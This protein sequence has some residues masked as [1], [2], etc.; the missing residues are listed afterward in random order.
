M[1]IFLTID[2]GQK[3]AVKSP[4]ELRQAWD[5]LESGRTIVSA[6]RDNGL[7]VPLPM[8]RAAILHPECDDFVFTV[9][10]R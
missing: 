1:E 6:V 7:A 9:E 2:D 3:I 5:N 10:G 4:D 8:V